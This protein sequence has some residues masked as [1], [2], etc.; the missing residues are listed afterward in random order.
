MIFRSERQFTGAVVDLAK[1]NGWLVHHDRMRQNVQG[2]AGFPDLVMVRN[3]RAIL[4][5]LKMPK[6][7]LTPEQALW[8]VEVRRVEGLWCELWYPGDWDSIVEV[9]SARC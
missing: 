7:K 4:A 8:L 5:E 3:G 9:L 2:T 6:G 1:M